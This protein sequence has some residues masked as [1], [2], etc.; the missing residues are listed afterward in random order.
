M[1]RMPVRDAAVLTGPRVHLEDNP[2]F[3]PAKRA[4]AIPPPVPRILT[5]PDIRK[6][7][8]PLPVLEDAME[9]DFD[10]GVEPASVRRGAKRASSMCE[11]RAN[12][13]DMEVC[14][15]TA[16]E[17]CN[18]DAVEILSWYA[19]VGGIK[20]GQI[21]VQ[22]CEMFRRPHKYA[23]SSMQTVTSKTTSHKAKRDETPP[24]VVTHEYADAMCAPPRTRALRSVI[25]RMMSKCRT[26]QLESCDTLSAIFH[27]WLERG[28]WVKPPRDPRLIDDRCFK[29]TRALLL[30]SPG[31][32]Q[33]VPAWRQ[34]RSVWRTWQG[35]LR[36]GV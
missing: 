7:T 4:C 30:L 18:R 2:M 3:S 1:T 34:T 24:R 20:T 17:C 32:S 23:K 35:S 15:D 19:T 31:A 27:A 36:S 25:R 5:Q 26:R 28:V 13:T 21:Q 9:V 16:G 12:Q 6:E 11:E 29:L 33:E 14:P 10:A 8:V 22:E